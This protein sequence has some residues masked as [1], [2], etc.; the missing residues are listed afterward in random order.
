MLPSI[1]LT[2]KGQHED[3]TLDEARELQRDLAAVLDSRHETV[4]IVNPPLES[5]FDDPSQ[6]AVPN[7][8]RTLRRDYG[9]ITGA[10]D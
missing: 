3:F 10:W 1:C 4:I 8:R 6:V 7:V 5:G 9:F 2:I